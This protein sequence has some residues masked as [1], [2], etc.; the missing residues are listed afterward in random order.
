MDLTNGMNN[1]YIY[2]KNHRMLIICYAMLCYAKYN[3]NVTYVIFTR[4][5][6]HYSLIH[7]MS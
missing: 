2:I 6:I 5:S 3:I 1:Y 7:F 4:Y